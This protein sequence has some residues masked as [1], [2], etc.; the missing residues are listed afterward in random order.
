MDGFFERS[1]GGAK[2]ARALPLRDATNLDSQVPPFE[3]ASVQDR[4]AL[5][6]FAVHASG[7]PYAARHL[8]GLGVASAC[9]PNVFRLTPFSVRIVPSTRVSSTMDLFKS[10]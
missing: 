6:K 4:V 10:V 8:L 5:L 3:F 9:V 1:P 7:D 2:H